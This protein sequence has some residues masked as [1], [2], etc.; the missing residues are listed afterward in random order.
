VLLIRGGFDTA[1]KGIAAYSTTVLSLIFFLSKIFFA[2]AGKSSGELL[3]KVHVCVES[4]LGLVSL[5][6][7][8]LK[9]GRILH[10]TLTGQAIFQMY[11][12]SL[13]RFDVVKSVVQGFWLTQHNMS[14]HNIQYIHA[15]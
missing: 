11:I 8:H 12:W 7:M 9:H 1:A 14:H 10:S 2:S 13:Y 4:S 5:Y 6:K 3:I 15:I